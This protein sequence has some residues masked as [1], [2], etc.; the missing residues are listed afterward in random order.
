LPAAASFFREAARA[1]RTGASLLLAE[2]AGH[3]GD[4]EFAQE[5]AAAARAGLTAIDHPFLKGVSPRFRGNRDTRTIA[6][7]SSA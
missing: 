6:F 1:M 2:P 4:A 7:H 3:D 5:I